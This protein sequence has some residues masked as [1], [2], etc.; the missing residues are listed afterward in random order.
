MARPGSL[1]WLLGW[2]LRLAWRDY[3]AR[4][5]RGGRSIGR[6]RMGLNL[7][8]LLVLLHA[9]GW[10]FVFVAR[11]GHPGEPMQLLLLSVVLCVSLFTAISVTIATAVNLLFVRGDL[12]LLCASPL[13]TRQVF[14]VRSLGIGLQAVAFPA[15]LLLPAAD[16][17]TLIDGPRWLA[18][19]PMILAL[20]LVSTAAG[21]ALTILLVRGIGPRR[22]R[23]VALVL[24]MLLGASFLLT[25]QGPK[26]L[27]DERRR[28]LGEAI[29]RWLANSPLAAPDSWLWLPARA[30]RGEAG[31]LCLS[32]ALAALCFA[33]TALLLPRGF[34]YALLHSAGAESPGRTAPG[35]T[36]PFHTRLWRIMFFKEW[37][38]VYRDPQL[39]VVLLQQMI[40]FIPAFI[41]LGRRS[42]LSE[43]ARLGTMACL[44]TVVAGVLA[45]TLAWLA[46]C[47]EDMPELLACAPR[48]RGALRRIK[49]A[50]ML[51]PLWLVAV[52]LAAW[53]AWPNPW[54]F[55]ALLLCIAGN[56]LSNGV[57]QLWLP[58]P[59]SRKDIRRRL[60]RGNVP[61]DRTLASLSMQFGWGGFA[62]C[63][64]SLHLL[65]AVLVLPLA[66]AGPLYAWLRSSGDEVLGY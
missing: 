23:T 38:L 62:W 54:L 13:P 19:Y 14:T 40:G 35:R 61:L 27:G 44:I 64:A 46:L 26:L 3:S 11:A 45:A 34:A 17:A 15:M 18:A 59:G 1:V 6:L 8:F 66:L 28:Q 49:L 55:L 65:A 31:P 42:G 4:F 41:L 25:M 7:L 10:S 63:L 16:V 9:M 52:A 2:E 32:L 47:A 60:R 43:A 33:L 50:V 56:S 36:Q 5:R 12:D 37:R 57:F 30:A 48:P 22:A 39:V 20:G 29:T 21:L 24:S 51:L 53:V 58:L